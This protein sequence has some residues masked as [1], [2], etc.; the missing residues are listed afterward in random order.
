MNQN[1]SLVCVQLFEK[2][3][4]TISFVSGTDIASVCHY[5]KLHGKENSGEASV[6]SE[7]PPRHAFRARC[8]REERECMGE[9]AHGDEEAYPE[10]GYSQR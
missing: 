4:G 10:E 9:S 2:P 6:I 7:G 3:V 1:D 8:R 5:E